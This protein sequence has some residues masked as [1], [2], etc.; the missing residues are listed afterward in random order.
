MDTAKPWLVAIGSYCKISGDVKILAHDTGKSVLI[1]AYHD[2]VG[3]SAPCVIGNNVF[4]GMGATILMGSRIG[5]NCIIG[6][7][8]V[9]KGTIPEN[10]IVAGNPG[11]VIC[12][13]QEYYSKRCE[14]VVEEAVACVKHSMQYRGK[15]PTIAEMGDGFAW[16]Y[17][18]R[19]EETLQRYSK[20][21][22]LKGES[23]AEMKAYF[24]NS[25]GQWNSY[26]EFLEYAKQRID[27]ESKHL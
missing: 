6:A 9:I 20:F 13:L 2:N 19:N 23:K 4:I 18:P 7:G 21:F 1:M 8:A 11:K 17:L 25:I 16:L 10:S 12:T 22:A 14:K 27:A 26:E 24:M 5:D 15:V 3:G